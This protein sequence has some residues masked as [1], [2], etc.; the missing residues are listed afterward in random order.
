MSDQNDLE[1]IPVGFKL[2]PKHR[3]KLDLLREIKSKT[4][5]YHV[6][7]QQFFAE[8]IDELPTE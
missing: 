2:S 8:L 7:I 4:K 1:M 6:T 5:G 3:E